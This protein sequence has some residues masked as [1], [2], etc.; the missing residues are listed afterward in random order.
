MND[1]DKVVL[2]VD[3]GGSKYMM[4]L[5]SQSGKIIY[6]ERRVWTE[7]TAENI[8]REI[9]AAIEEILTRFPEYNVQAAGMTIPGLADPA[10][11]MWVS[12]SFA[13][14]RN[15]PIANIIGDRFGFPVFID[16]DC[17]ACALA[18][19]YFGTCRDCNDFMYV[20]VSTGIGGALFLNGE[21]YYGAFG[22]AGELGECVIVEDGRL[23][24]GG[25]RGTLEAYAS[26]SGL[27]ENY[28][29][30]GGAE[31]LDGDK[32]DGQSISRL[33]DMGDKSALRAFELEGYYLGKVVATACNLLDFRKVVIGGGL[34]LA[35][36]HYRHA[37]E[38][39]VRKNTFVR[40]NG[41]LEIVPT[42]LGYDGALMGAATLAIRG[43]E[44][45]TS[46]SL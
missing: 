5:I 21:L 4:G 12:H 8:I 38:E 35:F 11:G 27:V 31:T 46:V 2:A 7:F 15:L 40:E 36:K 22:N 29:E 6:K 30:A 23:S 45:N 28:L 32:P 43:L 10:A 19:K 14:V 13:N 18:E 16:N 24:E 26:A 9:G 42:I 33:A 25:S 41:G 1:K 17:N 34:S 44:R 20:T 37:L 3:L 39:T